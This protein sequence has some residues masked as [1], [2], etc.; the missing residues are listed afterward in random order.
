MT[1]RFFKV[2]FKGLAP[3]QAPDEFKRK[4]TVI[5]KNDPSKIELYFQGKPVIIKKGVDQATARKY[6]EAFEKA[7]AIIQ[8]LPEE[9]NKVISTPAPETKPQPMDPPS[10]TFKLAGRPPQPGHIPP[11]LP[12]GK[13]IQ[14]E[15]EK[16][17]SLQVGSMVAMAGTMIDEA[18]HEP[19][20]FL[21]ELPKVFTYP[22]SGNG[23][24]I[25][26]S[27]VLFFILIGYVPVVGFL[28]ILMGLA[29]YS[30][31]MIKVI[32]SSANG[33]ETPPPWPDFADFSSDIVMPAIKVIWVSLV[34]YIPALAYLILVSGLSG[35]ISPV[36]WLLLIIGS[37]YYPMALLT[38]AMSGNFMALNPLV[39]VPAVFKMPRDYAIC[40]LAWMALI[41]VNYLTKWILAV[42]IPLVGPAIQAFLTLY[43]A[44][45]EMRVLGLMY[46]ANDEKLGW[47]T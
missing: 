47:Y 43:F 36:F 12:T 8:V 22:F 1:D 45:M 19:I 21:A 26:G 23:L 15:D 20:D 27:G 35:I 38:V 17:T 46:R 30:A 16:P 37:I 34:C 39:V 5:Y 11:Q 2:V 13:L 7:G 31:Y 42:G 3:N 4:L 24:F 10:Q 29:Y 14:P 41:V 9:P 40:L 25:I 32:T 33:D 44:M 28:L 6:Q 18:D